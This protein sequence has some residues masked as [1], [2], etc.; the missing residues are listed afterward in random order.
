MLTQRAQWQE[1][2]SPVGINPPLAAREAP[3]ERGAAVSGLPLPSLP[4]AKPQ[5]LP[6][7]Q[8]YWGDTEHP[9]VLQRWHQARGGAQN[10]PRDSEGV[11][12]I[13][14]GWLSTGGTGT[15]PGFPAEP[16]SHSPTGGI[17]VPS[18]SPVPATSSLP[19]ARCQQQGKRRLF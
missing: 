4:S 13:G 11:G 6:H 12:I 19:A 5:E 2:K 1:N 7:D 10:Q 8:G 16:L 18:P 17:L 15:G 3:S 14:L 9:G